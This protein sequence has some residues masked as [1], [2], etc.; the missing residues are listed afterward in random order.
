M[1]VSH[2]FTRDLSIETET[3]DPRI[4]VIVCFNYDCSSK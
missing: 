2:E 3:L 4:Q 1:S